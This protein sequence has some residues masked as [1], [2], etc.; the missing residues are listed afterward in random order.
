MLTKDPKKRINMEQLKKN[1][2]VNQGYNSNLNDKGANMLAN[3]TQ[4]E[5]KQK[6]INVQ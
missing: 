2:W 4:E 5:L 3:L 1:K 6:G